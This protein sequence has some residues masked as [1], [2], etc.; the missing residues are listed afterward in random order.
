M[1]KNHQPARKWVSANY[2]AGYFEVTPKTIWDWAKKGKLP[3]PQKIG[4]NTTRWDFEKI[5][6]SEAA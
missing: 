4:E 2:L 6:E 5:Q 3:P 1:S